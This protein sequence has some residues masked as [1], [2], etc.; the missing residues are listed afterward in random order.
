MKVPIRPADRS[1]EVY[2]RAA[3]VKSLD[4]RVVSTLELFEHWR[5]ENWAA[6]RHTV[7]GT[8]NSGPKPPEPPAAVRRPWWKRPSG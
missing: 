8:T 4:V 1:P 2:N 5:T 6:L 3:F 7:L